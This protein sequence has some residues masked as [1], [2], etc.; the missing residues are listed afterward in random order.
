MLPIKGLKKKLLKTFFW[1]FLLNKDSSLNISYVYLSSLLCFPHILE[2]HQLW[3]LLFGC[4]PGRCL[5]HHATLIFLAKPA[6]RP[7]SYRKRHEIQ[8]SR[9]WLKLL[10]NFWNGKNSQFKISFPIQRF[11]DPIVALFPWHYFF[12]LSRLS[13]SYS[14]FDFVWFFHSC[15]KIRALTLDA[16]VLSSRKQRP[17]GNGCLCNFASCHVQ[18][19]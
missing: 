5:G 4:Q 6:T 18:N 2:G 10:I 13:V 11:S 3:T 16:R 17:I 8:L 19:V 9:M 14:M 1:I 15:F 7:P 12:L